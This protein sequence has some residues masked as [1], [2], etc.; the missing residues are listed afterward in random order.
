M[1]A[2]LEDAAGVMAALPARRMALPSMVRIKRRR[3]DQSLPSFLLG[4][5]AKSVRLDVQSLS[6][7]SDAQDGLAAGSYLGARPRYRLV[8]SS[9]DSV[10]SHRISE[11]ADERQQASRKLQQAA[12][13]T[14]IAM[15]RSS[16]SADPDVL[17]LQRHSSAPKLQP[18]GAPLPPK[19]ASRQ[20]RWVQP[21]PLERWAETAEPAPR[22]GD[23]EE[24]LAQLWRD[25]AAAAAA[26]T[27]QGLEHAT[28]DL[29]EEYVFDEYIPVADADEEGEDVFEEEIWWEEPI[30]EA[31]DEGTCYSDDDSNAEGQDYPEDESSTHDSDENSND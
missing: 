31:W 11:P 13:F 15:R 23:L 7:S 20:E 21:G 8:R 25:A 17:E 18:F 28:H 3:E 9:T 16:N 26:E 14:L 4:G 30:D 29:G 10:K 2:Q 1:D 19:E 12:R 22:P 6:L 24:E 27:K 5:R